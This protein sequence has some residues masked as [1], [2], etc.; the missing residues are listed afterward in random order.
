M[1][2]KLKII[3]NKSVMLLFYIIIS[4]KSIFYYKVWSMNSRIPEARFGKKVEVCVC[5]LLS[6]FYFSPNDNP[7]KSMKN[8]FYFI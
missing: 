3:L 7:L 8:D 5:Y 1:L 4:Y 2:E 6:N